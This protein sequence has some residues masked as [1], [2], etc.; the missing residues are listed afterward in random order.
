MRTQTF[1]LLRLR[2]LSRHHVF[3]EAHILRSSLKI[4]AIESV[5]D[6]GLSVVSG[7]RT[8]ERA[9]IMTHD[10]GLRKLRA[11]LSELFEEDPG[12]R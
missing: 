4:S 3:R 12:C 8:R 5:L 2:Y 1:W 7:R 6:I 11:I 10:V 9:V